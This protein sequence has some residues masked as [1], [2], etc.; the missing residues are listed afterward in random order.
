MSSL[1]HRIVEYAA[2][3]PEGAPLCPSALLH[4]GNRAAVDQALSRLARRGELLRICQ[5][6]YVRPVKTR[7]GFRAPAVEKVIAALAALWGETIVA[8]GASAAHVL[9]L[10]TQMPV[11]LSTTTTGC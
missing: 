9:G 4:L 3:L 6:V 10:T 5:G 8:C 1:P 2:T 11:R 7:F